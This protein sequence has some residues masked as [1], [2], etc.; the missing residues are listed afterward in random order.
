MIVIKTITTEGAKLLESIARP[1]WE[2]HYT[3]IIGAEQVEYMLNKFQSEAAIKT[4]FEQGFDYF[5]VYCKDVPA[6][7]MG[8][9]IKED[10]LFISKFYLNIAFRGQGIAHHMLARLHQLA[11]TKGLKQLEL[12]VNKYNPAYEVYLK[13]GF[14]N[15]DSVVI[16]IGNG[17]IMDDYRLVKSL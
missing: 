10:S 14:K 3:P 6:G 2:Q 13:M 12:T 8:I 15:I 1:I 16:D 9:Q 17:Y 11:H 5:I 7:Y 4:Q